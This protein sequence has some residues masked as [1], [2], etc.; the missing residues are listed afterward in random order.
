MAGWVLIEASASATA[1]QKGHA[2]A[3]TPEAISTVP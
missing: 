3:G 2:A 1:A